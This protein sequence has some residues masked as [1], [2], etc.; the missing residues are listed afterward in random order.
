MAHHWN[1]FVSYLIDT[2]IEM[3]EPFEENGLRLLARGSLRAA[4]EAIR[5]YDAAKR[6]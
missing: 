2:T 5:S 3:G 4:K 6:R 1:L